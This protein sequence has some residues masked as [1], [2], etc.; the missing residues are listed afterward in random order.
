M[1][2]IAPVVFKIK[3]QKIIILIGKLE[4]K[5][6][7]IY[8]EKENVLLF[9]VEILT[10]SYVVVS[11]KLMSLANNGIFEVNNKFFKILFKKKKKKKKK[12]Y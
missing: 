6:K 4:T 3:I 7:I 8:S 11:L 5:R 2:V 1:V 12:K 9:S 10:L